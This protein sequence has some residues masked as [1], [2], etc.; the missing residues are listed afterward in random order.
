MIDKLSQLLIKTGES[1]FLVASYADVFSVVMQCSSPRGA[2][3]D[4]TKNAY[5]GG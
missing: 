5:K 4:Y 2:L 1:Q 3:C